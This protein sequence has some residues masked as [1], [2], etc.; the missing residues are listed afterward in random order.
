MHY[1]TVTLTGLYGSMSRDAPWPTRQLAP[2]YARYGPLASCC[3]VRVCAWR[4]AGCA[5]RGATSH[6]G[7][8]S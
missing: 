7:A 8:G 4:A 5:G 6:G 2:G 1:A 3:A